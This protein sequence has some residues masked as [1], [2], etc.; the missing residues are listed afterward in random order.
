MSKIHLTIDSS[1]EN[2]DMVR[3]CV[4]AMAVKLF[5]ELQC[6]QIELC[7]VEAVTNCIVHSYKNFENKTVTVSYRMDETKAVIDIIDSGFAMD[8]RF[9]QDV[10]PVFALDLIDLDNIPENGRGLKVI[11][12]WMDEAYYY[13]EDG[14]N[15]MTLVKFIDSSKDVDVF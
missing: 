12:A 6:Y 2:I 9:F 8:T 11:K 3:T 4:G 13:S 14:V 10:S 5:D 7:V 15:H 1:L